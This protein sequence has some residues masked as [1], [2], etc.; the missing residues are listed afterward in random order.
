MGSQRPCEGIHTQTK[1]RAKFNKDVKI[2]KADFFLLFARRRVK[3]Q[4]PPARGGFTPS[5]MSTGR[6][7][8]EAQGKVSTAAAVDLRNFLKKV[9]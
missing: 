8:S 9:P 4:N 5:G 7:H 6:R 2:R 3:E 1:S